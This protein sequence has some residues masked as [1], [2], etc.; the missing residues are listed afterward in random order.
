[1]AF[2]AAKSRNRTL[3]RIEL[4][5]THC[6]FVMFTFDTYQGHNDSS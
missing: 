1:M 3:R 5:T 4:L 2:K 6:T